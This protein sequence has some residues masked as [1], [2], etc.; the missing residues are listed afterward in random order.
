VTR[1]LDTDTC[2]HLLRGVEAT[3]AHVQKFSPGALG[4]S[5]ITRYELLLGVEK[6]PPAWKKKEGAKVHLLLDHL[7]IL[8]FTGDT[9]AIAAR[10]RASL[11]TIG[12]PIGPMD[13]L[14]AS[15]A[16][17]N[18]L[19]LVTTNLKEFQRV[20]GLACETWLEV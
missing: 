17:E 10:V 20:P 6:C 16:L 5:A 7:H 12:R 18:D 1:L 9:A 14:I 13:I 2:I 15:T 19:P 4:V 11:E 3:V 8:P